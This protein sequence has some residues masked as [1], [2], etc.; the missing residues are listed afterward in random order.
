MSEIE[1]YIHIISEH[2][3]LSQEEAIRTFQ[4]ILLGGATPAQ[5]AAILMGLR[6]KGETVDEIYGA[7]LV[8]LSKAEKIKAPDL[9][10]DCCGTGG[11]HAGTL[12]ISTAA[13]FVIAGCGVHVAKHGN[14]AVSSNSG[15]ADVFSALHVNINAAKEKQEKAL[16]E[17]GICFLMAPLYHPA[18]RYVS[19]IRQELQIKS[20]FNLL[21][22]LASPANPKYQLIGVYDK[23]LQLI[24]AEILRRQGIKRA[25][26]VTGEDGM[27][28]I[29]IAGKSFVT[30]VDGD[31]I[32]QFE[33]S[34][35]DVGIDIT[36]S[37]EVA[38]GDIKY[39]AMRLYDLLDG[40]QDAYRDIVLMNAAAALVVTQKAQN[41]L[42]GVEMARE[43]IDCGKAKAALKKLV[44]ITGAF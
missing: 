1:K 40:K 13:A 5:I 31:K 38:G 27:D 43:S 32:H 2:K 17:A 26:I 18:A 30:E 37:E 3:N 10:I 7:L 41:L 36:D 15:S 14:K 34:P 28:E 19:P 33:I 16:Q 25:W 29:T 44:E 23:N 4:I 21:G 8:M 20:I 35:Q 12:N 24:F 22:P 11:D 42:E 9:T 6:V 39:N